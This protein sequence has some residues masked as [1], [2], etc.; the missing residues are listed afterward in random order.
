MRPHARLYFERGL[1]S[2]LRQP[3]L[4]FFLFD[5]RGIGFLLVL[6]RLFG[7][8]LQCKLPK[9]MQRLLYGR[10]FFLF[11]QNSRVP[12][13]GETCFFAGSSIGLLFFV[14]KTKRFQVHLDPVF[15]G[16]E[17][18]NPL[19]KIVR[20]FPVGGLY[21]E[22]NGLKFVPEL[23][24]RHAQCFCNLYKAHIFKQNAK[25]SID[26]LRNS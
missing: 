25:R 17:P 22:I 12:G 4:F 5:K 18:D 11:L 23:L 19:C 9:H 1:G 2:F 13:F 16:N 10:F 3:K 21:A 7:Y 6:N 26:V 15:S 24:S 14:R 8:I 20:H